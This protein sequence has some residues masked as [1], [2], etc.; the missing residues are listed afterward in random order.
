MKIS[1][2]IEKILKKFQKKIEVNIMQLFTKN[3][4]KN[5]TF[6][7]LFRNIPGFFIRIESIRCTDSSVFHVKFFL[8]KLLPIRICK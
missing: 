8:S 6:K 7:M 5:E 4:G 2:N 3:F 1:G